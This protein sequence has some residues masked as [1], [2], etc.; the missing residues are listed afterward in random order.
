MTV[1]KNGNPVNSGILFDVRITADANSNSIVV[2]GP[3][4]SMS[5]IET[6]VERLDVVPDI[7]SRSRSSA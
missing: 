4:R 6:L 7:E 5:L 3:S 2:T 1:D